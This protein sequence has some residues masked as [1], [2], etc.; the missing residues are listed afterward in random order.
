MDANGIRL[1][2]LLAQ[3]VKLTETS[4]PEDAPH[5][6]R[7]TIR[8]GTG[9]LAGEALL[10]EKSLRCLLDSVVSLVHWVQQEQPGALVGPGSPLDDQ[11]AFDETFAEL[12]AREGEWPS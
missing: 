12:I 9:Q 1:T 4:T 8:T 2:D 5:V 11:E 3:L 10:T 6:G 7:I